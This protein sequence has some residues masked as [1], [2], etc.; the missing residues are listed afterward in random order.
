MKKML[1]TGLAYLSLS[2]PSYGQ[3]ALTIE[4]A[5]DIAEENSPPCVVPT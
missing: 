4:K 5:M 1:L 3:I 2:V